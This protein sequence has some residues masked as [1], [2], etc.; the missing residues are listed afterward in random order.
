[1][2]CINFQYRDLL[3]TTY[4]NIYEIAYQTGFR[5]PAYF[6]SSFS[7]EFGTRP[8]ADIP[9]GAA[10]EWRQIDGVTFK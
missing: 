8:S 5:D 10:S 6:S 2:Y 7:E 9:Y 1:M 4:L 3:L